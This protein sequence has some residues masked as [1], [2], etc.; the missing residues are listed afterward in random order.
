MNAQW[1]QRQTPSRTP[2]QPQQHFVGRRG[3]NNILSLLF[4]FKLKSCFS[5]DSSIDMKPQ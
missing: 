2:L 5:L 1:L 4:W 3:K